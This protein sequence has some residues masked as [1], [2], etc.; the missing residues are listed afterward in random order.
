MLLILPVIGLINVA[1]A[2]I[3]ASDL[4]SSIT[5]LKSTN[6]TDMFFT[7]ADLT[8]ILKFLGPLPVFR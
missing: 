4:T 2:G 7:N 6:R 5:V 1:T 8:K 3:S